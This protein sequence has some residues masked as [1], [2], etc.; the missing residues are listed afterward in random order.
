[1]S[2]HPSSTTAARALTKFRNGS[3][4]E[5]STSNNCNPR[6]ES[7]TGFQLNFFG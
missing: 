4:P 6:H 5:T 7:I 1:M 2:K 3:M